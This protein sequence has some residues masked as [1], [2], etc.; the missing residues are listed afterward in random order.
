[1]A[2]VAIIVAIAGLLLYQS[3]VKAPREEK[4]STALAKG[5]EYFNQEQFDKALNGDGASYAGFVKIASDYSG[6]DAANLADLYA[7]L[8]YANLGKWTEAVTYLEKF[9]TKNDAMIS[10]AAVAALGNAYA[11]T[12]N[13]DKAISTLKKAADMADSKAADDTN[14]SLSPTFLIQAAQLLEKTNKNDEALKIYQDIKKKYVN[15]QVVQS[16]E[17]DKYIERVAEK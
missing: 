4:A 2:V 10:P 1:I 7:G 9:S 14:N 3:F 17:I 8:C 12:G 5:Q 11:N 16:S 13:I 15:A 6:T